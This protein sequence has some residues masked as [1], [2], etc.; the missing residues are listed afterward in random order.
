MNRLKA[1][2]IMIIRKTPFFFAFNRAALA[3][4]LAS[5]NFS[6]SS[7]NEIYDTLRMIDENL[8]QNQRRVSS[9][10][11]QIKHARL[12][13]NVLNDYFNKP[14]TKVEESGEDTQ[15]QQVR[16]LAVNMSALELNT[17]EREALVRAGMERSARFYAKLYD[18]LSRRRQLPVVHANFD[19][20]NA[21]HDE[22][23][24]AEKEE[25]DTGAN[26]TNAALINEA[27]FLQFKT[28]QATP[29]SNPAIGS[30]FINQQQGNA[31][32]TPT[33]Q[34]KLNIL[35]QQQQQQLQQQQLTPQ[36]LMSI[37]QSGVSPHTMPLHIQQQ[38]QQFLQPLLMQ[39]QQQQQMLMLQKQQQFQQLQQQQQQQQPQQQIQSLQQLQ[40]PPQSQQ[41]QA[42]SMPAPASINQIN[43]SSSP[44][45][46]SFSFNL[47]VNQAKQTNEQKQQQQPVQSTVTKNLFG[48]Q[49]EAVKQQTKP[50]AEDTTKQ[51]SVLVPRST[52]ATAPSSTFSFNLNSN[53]VATSTQA[54]KQP[55]VKEPEQVAK[56][57]TDASS[58]AMAAADSASGKKEEATT[59]K[60]AAVNLFGNI[61]KPS[62]TPISASSSLVSL[63]GL[64]GGLS[65][66]PS[67]SFGLAQASAAAPVASSAAKETPTPS[68]IEKKEQQKPSGSSTAQVSSSSSATN[69]APAQAVSESATAPSAVASSPAS[70]A[71]VTNPSNTDK[72]ATANTTTATEATKEPAATKTST[73]TV[74]STMA[75]ASVAA[76]K[77][78]FGGF[79]F[80][81][82]DSTTTNPPVTSGLTF[83]KIAATAATTTTK[84]AEIAPSAGSADLQGTSLFSNFL[85]DKTATPPGTSA[86]SAA[87]TPAAIASPFGGGGVAAISNPFSAIAQTQKQQQQTT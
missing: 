16:Q 64:G 66:K 27:S 41:L 67:F 39:Q 49:T 85:K 37:L 10:Y 4:A 31:T 55:P 23:Y 40:K 17:E 77:P 50:A 75:Q 53:S 11:K 68:S 47:Q 26:Q 7:L 61:S 63:G 82:A 69:V 33:Q 74:A 65:S 43:A 29:L 22:T 86:A 21:L 52:N 1:L 58:A 87:A 45:T 13:R 79:S 34:N 36:Q 60:P 59:H 54:T 3:S 28:A 51:P 8:Q 78:A 72:L 19:Q 38:L 80:G 2:F 83:G 25:A 6:A 5:P 48:Q 71:A 62:E 12:D 73:T 30:I 24:S 84:P 20:L 35:Q 56:Q 57:S 42:P 44:V 14:A 15:Q 46:H 32:S 9:A 81:T 18:M 76:A 70:S